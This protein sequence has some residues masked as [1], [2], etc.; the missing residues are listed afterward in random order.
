MTDILFWTFLIGLCFALN[1]CCIFMLLIRHGQYKDPE[2]A[3]FRMYENEER[4]D[5]HF[6]PNVVHV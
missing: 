4:D 3:K 5:Q 1:G 2:K 6:D